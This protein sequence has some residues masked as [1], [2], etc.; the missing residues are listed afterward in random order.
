MAFAKLS[1]KLG[2][3]GSDTQG[4]PRMH[5]L[6][7]TFAVRKLLQWHREGTDIHTKTVALATYLGHV[8][9]SDTYWYL[10]SVPELVAI[11]AERFEA[12]QDR[13][14]QDI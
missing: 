5:D 1:E 11:V 9:V 12:L 6:R 14:G 2:W 7:H 3:H 8:K 4:P 10:T 13:K